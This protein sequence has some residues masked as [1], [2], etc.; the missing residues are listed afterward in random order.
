MRIYWSALR[1]LLVLGS[2]AVPSAAVEVPISIDAE[3]V[4]VDQTL[5]YRT[6]L[7]AG[8]SLRFIEEGMTAKAV[9]DA[10]RG[11]C[12]AT[13]SWRSDPKAPN[14]PQ[15][16]GPV[17]VCLANP[18]I[19]EDEFNAWRQGLGQ[20]TLPSIEIDL[21][22]S[23]TPQDNPNLIGKR[24]WTNLAAASARLFFRG[25][26]ESR[27]R[28]YSDLQ[29]QPGA[30][31]LTSWT[32]PQ[33]RFQIDLSAKNVSLDKPD[34]TTWQNLLQ[35]CN[36]T[37]QLP[38]KP[39][40]AVSQAFAGG[41]F[42]TP[43]D[44]STV[45]G[46]LTFLRDA[47]A[48]IVFQKR[49]GDRESKHLDETLDKIGSALLD[50]RADKALRELDQFRGQVGRFAN[51]GA[52]LPNDAEP[53]LSLAEGLTGSIET[54]FVQARLDSRPENYCPSSPACPKPPPCTVSSLYV[55]QESPPGGD[56]S[57]ER[58][59]QTITAALAKAQSA[60]ACGVDIRVRGGTYRGDLII[61]RDT[62]IQPEGG[63]ATIEGSVINRGPHRLAISSIQIL[64]ISIAGADAFGVDVD[65]PCAK[66]IL[67]EVAIVGATGYGV[68]QRGGTLAVVQSLVWGTRSQPSFVTR[69][70]GIYLTCGTRATFTSLHLVQNESAALQVSGTGT[71]VSATDLR[72]D[73]T[74]D[75]PT[76]GLD[77][78]GVPL[79]M[80]ALQVR[81]GALLSANFFRVQRSRGAGIAVMGGGRAFF[82]NGAVRET[83]PR[84]CVVTTCPEAPYGHNAITHDGGRLS[85]RN[86]TLTRA[87]LCGLMM[88]AGVTGHGEAD[89]SF[90]EISSSPIGICLQVPG[91]PRA[92]LLD[93]V[94][95]TR[96]GRD[97]EGTAFAV[98][99]P[100]DPSELEP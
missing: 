32:D 99:E 21:A 93:H 31:Q 30:L 24:L 66:T 48:T 65:H 44:P 12:F 10:D 67:V 98:P 49:L 16:F 7:S 83:L 55:Q 45:F 96:V 15:L 20:R 62:S 97:I 41:S 90:G 73:D 60:G 87:E 9:L 6:L 86:F 76:P 51:D 100:S 27:F 77:S 68:R 58:P 43:P 89:L 64:P 52:I 33:G 39:L 8:G 42:R 13:V 28:K 82:E 94:T 91:Y 25:C 17:V 71:E 74:G 29:F 22:A 11:V 35:S 19:T 84:S 50:A 92:R 70:T 75:H 79:G 14:T 3:F 36:L 88:S 2:C 46:R 5:A 59:F 57:A 78:G 47:L 61:T 72:I 56:G 80:G 40:P 85:M 95:F 81:F 23:Q 1:T 26:G 34:E 63:R 18:T 4:H 37:Q 69:G 38:A 54:L 53:L